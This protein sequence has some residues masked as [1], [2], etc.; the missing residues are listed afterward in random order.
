MR[1]GKKSDE[2]TFYAN[3][4]V[5]R[6]KKPLKN[7]VYLIELSKL[8][9]VKPEDLEK[10]KEELAKYKF[11]EEGYLVLNWQY[12]DLYNKNFGWNFHGYI[13]PEDLKK[14]LGDKQW[15]KLCQGKRLFIIQRRVNG[16]NV[17]KKKKDANS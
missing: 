5:E 2:S 11:K 12:E 3:R 7:K 10:R 6:N 14:K 13:T 8:E 4:G 15:A 16:K 1:S 17:K 9:R